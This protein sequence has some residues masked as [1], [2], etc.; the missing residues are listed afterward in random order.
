MPSPTLRSPVGARAGRN[1]S[2]FLFQWEAADGLDDLGRLV[3]RTGQVGTFSRGGTVGAATYVDSAGRIGLAGK[4][5]PRFHCQYNETTGL[6]E[7][8]GLLLE[9]ARTN[10]VVQSDAL[11]T[12]WGPS[13]CTA[14]NAYATKA[15]RSFSRLSGLSNI[16]FARR[17]VTFTG[18]GT[19]GFAIMIC[20]DGVAGYGE[21]VLYDSSAAAVRAVLRYTVAASGV[22]TG[23]CST[24]TLLATE[25][26]GEG[27]YR[28][29]VQ[30]PSVVAANT[31]YIYPF[32]DGIGAT[33]TSVL[34]SGI[35]AEDAAFL[36][37][38]IPTTTTTVT[39][40]A[41]VLTF[42]FNAVPQAM[43][44]YYKGFFLGGISPAPYFVVVGTDET[45]TGPRIEMPMDS[46]NFYARYNS[47]SAS[48]D[49]NPNHGGL[50]VGDQIELL[51]QL[52]VSGSLGTMTGS[53]SVDGGT[54]VTGPASASFSMPAAF[55]VAA[56][57]LYGW[58]GSEPYSATQSVRI[59]AGVQTMDYMRAG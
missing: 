55:D 7:P 29:L 26:L 37:S 56:V 41:D 25:S 19:K 8:V 32:S 39:R 46:S 42:A 47:N 34:I 59:A 15:G 50:S 5:Q 35:H 3:A 48:Y 17:T 2:R 4:Q 33:L 20:S 51:A 38:T 6:F 54:A 49:S 31:N 23:A 1:A 43:T 28:F 45:P 10:L 11:N 21:A 53:V 44:V 27:A 58:G 36:S 9:G 14:T 16:S 30:A 40:S 24:G 22:V 18:D 52:S 13:N 12:G 57:K